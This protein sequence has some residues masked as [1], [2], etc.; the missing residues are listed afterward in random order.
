MLN[1]GFNDVDLLVENEEVDSIT[2]ILCASNERLHN[3][4]NDEKADTKILL[5]DQITKKAFSLL[6]CYYGYATIDIDEENV[7]ELFMCCICLNEPNL[8]SK[9]KNFI[10][11][12]LY[13]KLVIDIINQIMY[14]PEDYLNDLKTAVCDYICLNCTSI[15]DDENI[16]RRLRLNNINFIVNL[17]NLLIPSEQYLLDRILKHY[18]DGIENIENKNEQYNETI[19]KLNWKEINMCKIDKRDLNVIDMNIMKKSI[20]EQSRK[21]K[22]G[23]IPR[24]G[25]EI[26]NGVILNGIKDIDKIKNLF[27][28]LILLYL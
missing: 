21:R 19:E 9:C 25:N 5:P 7:T 14:L 24:T 10:L 8:L 12:H 28:I 13:N 6:C 18:N 3:I 11:S 17:E 1:K 16:F 15:L 4:I 2:S 23:R 22:Y 26:L 20:S 27:C